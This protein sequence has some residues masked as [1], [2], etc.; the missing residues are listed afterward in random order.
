MRLLKVLGRPHMVPGLALK[1]L[2]EWGD[3]RDIY[4]G[5]ITQ[6]RIWDFHDLFMAAHVGFG[7]TV[8][9]EQ[10]FGPRDVLECLLSDWRTTEQDE[11]TQLALLDILAFMACDAD[12]SIK[13]Q[14]F[15]K[16]CLQEASVISESIIQHHPRSMHTR[17]FLQWTIAQ[18]SVSLRKGHSVPPSYNDL[19][20]FCGLLE[21]AAD[22]GIPYYVPVNQEQPAWAPIDLPK[23]SI[24]HLNSVLEASRELQDYVTEAQCLGELILR[25]SNPSSQVD[26]L[27]QLQN[28]KQNNIQGYLQTSFSRYLLS[29]DPQSKA[30]LVADLKGFGPLRNASSLIFPDRACVR[31]I[32]LRA[33]SPKRSN[34]LIYSIN[35]SQPFYSLLP[36]KYQTWIDH[37]AENGHGQGSRQGNTDRATRDVYRYKTIEM[38]PMKKI[39]NI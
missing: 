37:Y 1:E 32:L 6:G 9:Q 31:D 13:S 30:K 24:S 16:R 25:V 22:T 28:E 7:T 3:W 4:E 39:T 20:N 29:T 34:S 18:A 33:L 26:E 2:R 10:F 11:S 14:R 19:R 8:A 21:T 36:N 17:P 27:L 12:N 5:L 35:A 15:A 23:G 38:K